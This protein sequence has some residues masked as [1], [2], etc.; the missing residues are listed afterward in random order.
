M[1]ADLGH[2]ALVDLEHEIDAVLVEL[3]D[4]GLDRGGEAAAAAIEVEDAL[5][6]GLD[7]RLR[8][9]RCAAAAE[10]RSSRCLVVDVVV[11]LEGQRD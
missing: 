7:P 6:V 8:C 1:R 11:A 4:L 10:L 3:D 9:R 5:D 2:V